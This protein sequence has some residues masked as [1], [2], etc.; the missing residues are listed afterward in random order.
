MA[1]RAIHTKVVNGLSTESFL[2]AYQRFTAVRGHPRKI[3]SDPGNNFIGAKTVLEELCRFLDGQNKAD[4][5]EIAAKGTEWMWKIHP[6]D[7]QHRN[8]AAEAAVRIVKRALQ[9]LGQESSLNY[10]EFQTAL[11]LAA[12]LSNERFF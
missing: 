1:S 4:L 7:S 2:M 6:A 12:N 5:E 10:S 8:G 9:N 3:W 11:Y